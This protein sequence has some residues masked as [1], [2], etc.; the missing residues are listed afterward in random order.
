MAQTDKAENSKVAPKIEEKSNQNQTAAPASTTAP[1]VPAQ[2][3]KNE[4][5][6]KLAAQIKEAENA[7]HAIKF[8][9]VAAKET[10][11]D[12][13]IK[14]LLSLFEKGTEPLRQVIL[15][16][17]H[18]NLSS[19]SDLKFIHTYDYFKA[20]SPNLDSSA[21]RMNVYRSMFNYHTSLEG[22][23]EMI[24]LLGSMD[25]DDAAKVLTYHYAR[26]CTY[27]SEANH[28]LRS[29][30]L[31]A[32]SKSNS[33]YA[34]NSLIEYARYTDNERVIGRIIGALSV[35]DEKIGSL[36]ISAKEKD[37]LRNQLQSLMALKDGE[38]HYR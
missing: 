28:F 8:Y 34:L 11:K 26:L 10:S 37:R 15:Y 19:S 3:Q 22:L 6:E 14:K 4:Q 32:L 33:H 9:P 21:I 25:G 12:E 18:E 13:A 35:W 23:C 20:K 16:M 30:I 5:D 17:I 2:I 27:E 31:D 36:K 24:K 1:P 38:K 29:A 7:M